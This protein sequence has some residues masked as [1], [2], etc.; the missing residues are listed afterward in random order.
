LLG[1]LDVGVNSAATLELVS[2]RPALEKTATELVLTI[3]VP[4]LFNPIDIVEDGD[5]EPKPERSVIA[6]EVF[7][8]TAFN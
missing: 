7:H 6:P 2:Q 5:A 8:C 3:A 4:W 1:G